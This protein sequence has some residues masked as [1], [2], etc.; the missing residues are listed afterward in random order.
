M[1]VPSG[2]ASL[3]LVLAVAA[4]ATGCSVPREGPA[5][6]EPQPA[7]EGTQRWLEQR[8][9]APGSGVATVTRIR[10][11]AGDAVFIERVDRAG[12][13]LAWRLT[14][15]AITS[16]GGTASLVIGGPPDAWAAHEDDIA[17]IA[18]FVQTRP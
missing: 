14:A 7:A 9:E 8:I 15:Y 4:V 11:P 3:A 1:T 17:R 13:P 18:A 10:L 12:T 6:A 16:A 2:H 5:T